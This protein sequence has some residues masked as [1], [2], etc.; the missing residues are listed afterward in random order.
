[1]ALALLELIVDHVPGAVPDFLPA[2]R[3]GRR[4]RT[5]AGPDRPRTAAGDHAR[6]HGNGEVLA[7]IDA[8]LAERVPFARGD[9]DPDDLAAAEG[10]AGE[11]AGRRA[12]LPDGRLKR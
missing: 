4:A 1:M 10:F 2:S 5:L 6:L 7:R 11:Q 3:R 8:E 12:P 9:G